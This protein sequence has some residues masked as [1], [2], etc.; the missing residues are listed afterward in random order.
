ML[1][2]FPSNQKK[3]LHVDDKVVVSY[4]QEEHEGHPDLPA[5]HPENMGRGGRGWMKSNI[6]TYQT[7]PPSQLLTTV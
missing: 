3:C 6:T 2:P 7:P 4:M 1:P 5:G